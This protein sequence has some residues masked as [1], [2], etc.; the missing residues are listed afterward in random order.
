MACETDSNDTN[1]VID[2]SVQ[3]AKSQETNSCSQPKIDNKMAAPAA[4]EENMAALK[5]KEGEQEA[6]S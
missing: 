3:F 1:Q 5:D 2:L 6:Y 4:V